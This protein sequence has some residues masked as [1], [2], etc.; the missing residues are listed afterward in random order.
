MAVF[1]VG[2]RYGCEDSSIDPITILQRTKCYAIVENSLAVWRMRI[3]TDEK[4]TEFMVDR[5]VPKKWRNVFTY[6][7]T[8]EVQ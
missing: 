8:Y 5:S 6:K 1:E 3:W 7:A 4:G 2:K